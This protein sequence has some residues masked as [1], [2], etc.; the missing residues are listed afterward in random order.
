M[1]SEDIEKFVRIATTGDTTQIEWMF[2]KP[3]GRK[4]LETTILLII[5]QMPLTK[6]EK[7][8]YVESFV[9]IM[10]K[11]ETR[12]KHQKQGEKILKQAL[13]DSAE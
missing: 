7:F 3:G 2:K 9:K 13:K 8:N 10:D 1:K 6:E 11:M 4:F 5:N 12:I